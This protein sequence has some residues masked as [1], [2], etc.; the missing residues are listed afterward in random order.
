MMSLPVARSRRLRLLVTGVLALTVVGAGCDAPARRNPPRGA[1]DTTIDPTKI[2]TRDDIVQ[3]IQY[4]PQMP[5]LQQGDRLIGFKVTVYF[6]SGQTVKGAFV[7]GNILVWV[8]ELI[9][10]ADGRHERKLAHM[11]EFD[12]A[13]ALG[14][15]VT[16]RG[17]AGYFYGFPLAWPRELALEGKQVEIQFGY[18][19]ADKK[20]ILSSARRFKV[21]MPIG[22]RPPAEG[23]EP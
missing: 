20:L 8:Y 14:F 4:W 18:E 12:E 9:P 1:G 13:E 16:R 19:R 15:R 17:I 5:W 23:T 22:Y 11:W 3:I 2:E 10:V 6:V 21:P 7:P